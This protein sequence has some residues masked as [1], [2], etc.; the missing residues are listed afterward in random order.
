MMEETYGSEDRGLDRILALSDG[1]FAFSLTLLALSLIVPKISSGQVNV[2]LQEKLV[3][4][5]PGFFIFIWS[6]LIV[7]FYWMGHH[8]VFSFIR[9]YDLTLMWCNLIVLMFI[10]VVPF[11]TNLDI[12][13][14]NVQI[15]VMLSAFFYAIPGIMMVLLW[16]HASRSHR[17]VDS[18][19]S[20]ASIRL[21]QYRNLISPMV[22]LLSIPFSF[23]HP[24]V[25]ETIWFLI[26]PLHPIVKRLS[27]PKFKKA[28]K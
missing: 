28:R 19:L 13:F 5:I 3:D 27:A 9:R 7:S 22:F 21:T 2:E 16:W 23:I 24:Y 4:E 26:I 14:G 6:F 8:R 11:T 12:Q 17:L 20:S 15:A 1:I 18:E 25:T 10:A